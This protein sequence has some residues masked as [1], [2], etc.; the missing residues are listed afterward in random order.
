MARTQHVLPGISSA[1]YKTLAGGP[2]AP[3]RNYWF[4]DAV[5]DL[6]TAGQGAVVGDLAWVA[7]NSKAYVFIDTGS[8]TLW[9]F[10][11][12]QELAYAQYATDANPL[13]VGSY[14]LCTT[15]SVDM[16][17]A[18]A[19]QAEISI[20]FFEPS[21][22]S[23]TAYVL[24]NGVAAALLGSRSIAAAATRGPWHSTFRYTP[25]AGSHS[26]SLFV[27]VVSSSTLLAN[28]AASGYAPAT[29]TV[30]SC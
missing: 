30:K 27:N 15:G 28:P 29:V 4:C 18:Q 5:S 10:V 22:D 13:N 9:I 25:T 2:S 17:G 20:K 16:S 8:A 21:A 19:V 3:L 14:T 26:W 23:V 6:P 7:A 1:P 24:D 11:S 12:G